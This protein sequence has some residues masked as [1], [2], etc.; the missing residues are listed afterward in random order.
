MAQCT[1]GAQAATISQK[2]F[3]TTKNFV[4]KGIVARMLKKRVEI[5]QGGGQ[6]LEGE[7]LSAIALAYRI[8]CAAMW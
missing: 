7:K 3:L 8:P 6:D 2:C 4:P 5:D 1:F